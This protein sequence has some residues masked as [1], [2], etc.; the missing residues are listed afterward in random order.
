MRSKT[1]SK[2]MKLK[3][4]TT[5]TS[6][7]R[8]LILDYEDET[9]QVVEEEAEDTEPVS[10]DPTQN[11][12]LSKVQGILDKEPTP[13]VSPTIIVYFIVVVHVYWWLNKRTV[14][15][16]IEDKLLSGF[17]ICIFANIGGASSIGLPFFLYEGF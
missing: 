6:Q 5:R 10:T 12:F 11:S 8:T 13:Q 3:R 7:E 9:P 15:S 14:N 2:K 4:E 17:K 1:I 16:L